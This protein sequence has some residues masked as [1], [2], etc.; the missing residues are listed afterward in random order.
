M[1]GEITWLKYIN[2]VYVSDK[3]QL[4]DNPLKYARYGKYLMKYYGFVRAGAKIGVYVPQGFYGPHN[5][6]LRVFLQ[7]TWFT[8][9]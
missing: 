5:R 7:I 4:R 1:V 3:H 9:V 8:E 6:F 2:R